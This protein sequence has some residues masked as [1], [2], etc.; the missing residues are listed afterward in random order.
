MF[1]IDAL[2]VAT[3]WHRFALVA[4][5]RTIAY[6]AVYIYIYYCMYHCSIQYDIS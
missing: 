3:T 6:S 1:G 2:N 5:F 4:F